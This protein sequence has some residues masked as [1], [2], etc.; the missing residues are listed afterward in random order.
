MGKRS[1]KE[2]PV[3]IL[4]AVLKLQELQKLFT[5]P[6][7][8]IF[9]TQS[10]S[11]SR[12]LPENSTQSAPARTSLL[13]SSHR[14]ILTRFFGHT[15]HFRHCRE[16]AVLAAA[17]NTLPPP[18]TRPRRGATSAPRPSATPSAFGFRPALPGQAG[19]RLT[20]G[21]RFYTPYLW[22]YK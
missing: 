10:K 11:P 3:P 13:P 15:E 7:T 5:C 22:L 6:P 18:A 2:Q 14:G 1:Q 12:L 16:K 21:C 20:L 9:S 8:F 17:G 4:K 19:G